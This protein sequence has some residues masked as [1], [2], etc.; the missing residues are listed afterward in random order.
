MR[1][2]KRR[3]EKEA[4]LGW[5]VCFFVKAEGE[6]AVLRG[7]I[8]AFKSNVVEKIKRCEE[9]NEE[10]EEIFRKSGFKHV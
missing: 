2:K 7:E 3:G 10:I 9:E 5:V 8:Q 6:K 1:R 4:V